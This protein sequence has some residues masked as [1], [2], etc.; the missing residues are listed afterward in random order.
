MRFHSNCPSDV[1]EVEGREE[2][3]VCACGNPVI[4]SCVGAEE[5]RRPRGHESFAGRPAT[6][7][8]AGPDAVTGCG[9]WDCLFSVFLVEVAE[10]LLKGDDVGFKT[11]DLAF[12]VLYQTVARV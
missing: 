8:G 5:Y 6:E 2:Y 11:F 1:S 10:F 7:S 3:G 12:E 9:L 4:G